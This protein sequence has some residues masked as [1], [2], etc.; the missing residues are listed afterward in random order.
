M[1]LFWASKSRPRRSFVLVFRWQ[2][3][4]KKRQVDSLWS[5]PLSALHRP[6]KEKRKPLG[7]K[8]INS[9]HGREAKT[10]TFG[11][12]TEMLFALFSFPESSTSDLPKQIFHA[13][14]VTSWFKHRLQWE[15][16]RF[17]KAYYKRAP[18]SARRKAKTNQTELIFTSVY[19]ASGVKKTL[20]F[21]IKGL[22]FNLLHAHS[23]DFTLPSSGLR[24]FFFF[25]TFSL[26]RHR[27]SHKPPLWFLQLIHSNGF[28][29]H[30]LFCSCWLVI[31]GL[32]MFE[33]PRG[34]GALTV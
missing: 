31:M 21:H 17:Y 5:R 8:K 23:W 10:N 3:A 19:H 29:A 18:F 24:F 16:G 25:N 15:S 33:A 14:G 11:G 22:C 2:D 4:W 1:S 9:K 27:R 32:R 28:S 34:S 26:S 7:M 6:P 30:L 12:N 13:S 20:M